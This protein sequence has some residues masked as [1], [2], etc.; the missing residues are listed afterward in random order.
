[1]SDYIRIWKE[2]V[3]D[4]CQGAVLALTYTEQ[5]KQVKLRSRIACNP[6]KVKIV[7]DLNK[8]LELHRCSREN[9]FESLANSEIEHTCPL[10]MSNQK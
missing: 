6:R 8:S 3:V 7:C 4:V 10:S 2:T 5:E 1:M 9:C